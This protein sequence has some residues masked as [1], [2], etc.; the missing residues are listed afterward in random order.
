MIAAKF[1]AKLT[2]KDEHMHIPV[3]VPKVKPMVTFTPLKATIY[4]LSGMPKKSAAHRDGWTWELLRDAAQRTSTASHLRKFSEL[5]SNGALPKH[6]WTYLASALMYPF[7]KLLLEDRVDPKDPALRPVTVGSVLTRFGCRV[8]VRM[9]RMA[10]ATQLL[11]SHQFSFGI[12]GGVQQVIM[13]CTI[14]L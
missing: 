4:A 10:V 1:L 14:A 7:H 8:L 13:G 3:H 9:N 2:L 5:F 12:N 11:L 6:L